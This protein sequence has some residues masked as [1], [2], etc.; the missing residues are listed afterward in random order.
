MNTNN[1]DT[2]W[3]DLIKKGDRRAL[4]RAITLA[5]SSKNEDRQILQRLFE[6][7][8]PNENTFRI[9]VS[10]PPGVGKS[11]FIDHF[12]ASLAENNNVAVL[13]IDPSSPRSGG[14]ILGDK[15]RM[16]Q[17]SMLPNV[18]IRPSPG[19]KGYGGISPYSS[20]VIRLC[21]MAGYNIIILETIGVG[22]SETLARQ[23]TDHFVLL[24]LA[25]GG[26]DLQGIKRGIMELADTFV[27][28]KADNT[29]E[30]VMK[31]ALS[32]LNTALHLL[33]SEE[34]KPGVFSVSALNK[35]GMKA[36]ESHIMEVMNN[37]K[38]TTLWKARRVRQDVA[39]FQ[40]LIEQEMLRLVYSEAKL[41]DKYINL[42]SEVFASKLSVNQA[43]EKFMKYFREFGKK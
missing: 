2:G 41:K 35:L 36:V 42:E 22:Q 27:F 12:G 18:Y 31:K 17:L 37:E 14:S 40:F 25:G 11:T 7:E 1:Y 3:A 29:P 21:E 24:L 33:R 23:L 30:N 10:G 4:S 39:R 6:G 16:E 9:A 8:M 38:N 26:D 43:V 28:N 15:T 34:T 19:G 20:D 13:T 32:D 5:E